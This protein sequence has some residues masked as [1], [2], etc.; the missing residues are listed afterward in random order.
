V[1]KGSDNFHYHSLKVEIKLANK[2]NIC[3]ERPL[4]GWQIM[5]MLE[6]HKLESFII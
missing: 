4:R 3:R 5:P 1:R 6:N 2:D